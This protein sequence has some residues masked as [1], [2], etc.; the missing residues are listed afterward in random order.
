MEALEVLEL[1]KEFHEV[2]KALEVD[3]KVKRK[4]SLEKNSLLK[5]FSFSEIFLFLWIIFSFSLDFA[6]FPV[7]LPKS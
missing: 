7:F 3:K 1:A 2:E 5:N 4:F 6:L